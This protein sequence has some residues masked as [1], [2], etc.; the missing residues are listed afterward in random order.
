MV[1]HAEGPGRVGHV[2]QPHL[3]VEIGA[4]AGQDGAVWREGHREHLV[5]VAGQQRDRG[6]GMPR[7]D[8]GEDDA[9]AGEQQQ[10][11]AEEVAAEETVNVPADADACPGAAAVGADAQPWA[12]GGV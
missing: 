10:N 11:G 4:A 7:R 1:G 6:R 5:V 8:D 2:P 9:G 3:A 12:D